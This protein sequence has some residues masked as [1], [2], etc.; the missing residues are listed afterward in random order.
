MIDLIERLLERLFAPVYKHL[1]R[2]MTTLDDLNTAVA[3]VT[4]DFN[5]FA[6]DVQTQVAGLQ[7][8]LTALQGGSTPVDLS[9]PIAAL[10]TLDTTIKAAIAA[11]QPAAPAP[12]ATT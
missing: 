6:T 1:E 5:T 10:G 12:A 2:I 4:A 7:A 8:Q 9:G 11:T 3:T